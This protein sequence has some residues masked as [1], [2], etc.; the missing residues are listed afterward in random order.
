MICATKNESGLLGNQTLV[1]KTLSDKSRRKRVIPVFLIHLFG[2]LFAFIWKIYS[3]TDDNELHS[4]S[5]GNSESPIVQVPHVMRL[6][7]HASESTCRDLRV[8]AW[9]KIV[10]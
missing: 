9:Q 3:F 7:H 5:A 1:I 10:D 4:R 2:G 6:M 8:I